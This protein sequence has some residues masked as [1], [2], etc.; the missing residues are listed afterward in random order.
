MTILTERDEPAKRP[1]PT[2]ERG[3]P[4]SAGAHAER[5]N[6]AV[7]V[8]ARPVSSDADELR[9]DGYGHGV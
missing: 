3:A 5:K 1:Q 4:A 8:L 6:L 7:R 2:P 9:E